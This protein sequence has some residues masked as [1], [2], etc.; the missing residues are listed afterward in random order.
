MIN[1][2]KSEWAIVLGSIL[3]YV[4]GYSPTYPNNQYQ[5]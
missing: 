3:P 4:V 5:M 2:D 1:D